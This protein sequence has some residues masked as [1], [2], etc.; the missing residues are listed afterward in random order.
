MIQ[1]RATVEADLHS[2]FELDQICFAD[3][4]AYSLSEFCSLL[5]SKGTIGV[6]AEENDVLAGFAMAQFGRLRRSYGGH[7]VT[8]DVAPDFRRRG[9]G[10]LLM[11]DL[12][13]Q[14]RDAGASWLRLEVAVNNPTALSFYLGLGFE[15]IGQIRG[16]YHR[17]LDAIVMEKIL[18]QS[19]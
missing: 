17:G 13:G 1:L 7:V 2:L 19:D 8:I 15:A 9:V 6:V 4:I 14:V 3:G 11:G 5:R 16:Y 10:R 12:E 18:A